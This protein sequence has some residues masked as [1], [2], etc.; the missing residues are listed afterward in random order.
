LNV[1]KHYLQ[2]KADYDENHLEYVDTI[3]F[4][5]GGHSKRVFRALEKEL[6]VNMP[7]LLGILRDIGVQ[8]RY[9]GD[10]VYFD[11]GES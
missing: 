3:F 7:S 5:V 10:T 9:D 2:Y 4:V 6:L 11:Y 8:Q 1:E